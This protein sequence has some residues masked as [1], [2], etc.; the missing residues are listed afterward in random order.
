M[1]FEIKIN[2]NPLTELVPIEPA[3]VAIIFYH[4]FSSSKERT[5]FRARILCNLGYYV[6]LPEAIGHGLRRHEME[7]DYSKPDRHFWDILIKTITESPDLI[8]YLCKKRGFKP[9]QIVFAGH[10][11]GAMAAAG[12]FV[13][14]P[15]GKLA[16]FNGGLDYCALAD[17]YNRIFT[18]YD[19]KTRQEIMDK[20]RY[21]SPKEFLSKLENRDMLLIDGD[22]DVMVPTKYNEA[23]IKSLAP[24]FKDKSRLIYTV[25]HRTTHEMTIKSF[26]I[27]HNWLQEVM[28]DEQ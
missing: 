26:E 12:V 20:I 24:F 11:M 6:L 17:Y 9:N 15:M 21:Y 25:L 18:K 2:G 27:F 4:G 22:K 13:K 14:S 5:L 1:E 23:V 19:D 28:K 16:M 8:N 10:S 3:K 7:V